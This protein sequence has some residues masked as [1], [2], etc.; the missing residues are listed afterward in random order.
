MSDFRKPRPDYPIYP[1]AGYYRKRAQAFKR[2]K[3]RRGRKPKG[4]KLVPRGQAQ[5]QV[6]SQAQDFLIIKAQDEAR[7]ARELALTQAQEQ[8]EFRQLQ[9]QDI[10]DER[11]ERRRKERA[12]QEDLQIRRDE[13]ALA[14]AQQRGN[15]AIQREQ[16]RLQD[17]VADETARYRQ[18][19]LQLL[20]YQG[21]ERRQD[22]AQLEAQ[23]GRLYEAQERRMGENIEMF[24]TTVEALT[25][26]RPVDFRE[27]RGQEQTDLKLSPEDRRDRRSRSPSK[28]AA[29]SAG[30]ESL[31]T[32]PKGRERT[33]SPERERQVKQVK[34]QL[35]PK[36]QPEP[37]TEGGGGATNVPIETIEQTTRKGRDVKKPKRFEGGATT[38]ELAAAGGIEGQTPQ[39]GGSGSK[40]TTRRGKNSGKEET[41]VIGGK[42]SVS[43]TPVIGGSRE[44]LEQLAQGGGAKTAEQVKSEVAGVKLSPATT[45]GLTQ[46]QLS[47]DFDA[48]AQG[49]ETRAAQRKK[50]EKRQPASPTLDAEL[51]RVLKKK[52]DD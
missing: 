9:I 31:A 46:S 18:Q 14:A 34:Q 35:Q 28:E 29:V 50:K 7:K 10:E 26:R 5:P 25:D 37:E 8:A 20:D 12:R 27:V 49:V 45:G 3:G 2:P 39:R 52:F 51:Q 44:R 40:E 38:P 15:L 30:F 6:P 16:L 32:T 1:S 24:K 48:I 17:A 47:R 33:P 22:R 41:P 19:K 43:Q 42:Q 36:P 13:L 21:Q 4:K 11:V 23:F